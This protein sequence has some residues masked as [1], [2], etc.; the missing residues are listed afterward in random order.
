MIGDWT[1]IDVAFYPSLSALS[2]IV[3]ENDSFGLSD[4]IFANQKRKFR[5]D[6]V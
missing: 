5:N 4:F 6:P 3:N 2:E 1:E